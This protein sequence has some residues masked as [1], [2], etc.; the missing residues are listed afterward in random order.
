M[1]SNLPIKDQILVFL[2]SQT[3]GILTASQPSGLAVP[4]ASMQP[5]QS[6]SDVVDLMEIGLKNRAKSATSMN[7]RSS[8]SHR[9]FHRYY[10]FMS[11]DHL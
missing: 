11:K 5:V 9:F 10:M 3:L 1:E 7:A 8:R 4:D 6:T 2:D